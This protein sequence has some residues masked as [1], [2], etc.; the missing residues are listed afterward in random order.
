MLARMDKVILFF[1]D[2]GPEVCRDGC[3]E[4]KTLKER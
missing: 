1:R 2:A 4:R 3:D